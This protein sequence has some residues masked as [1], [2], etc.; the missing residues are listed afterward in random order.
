MC[1]HGSHHDHVPYSRP[2]TAHH[3][4][5]LTTPRTYDTHQL[6]VR[7]RQRDGGRRDDHDATHVAATEHHHLYHYTF[8][9]YYHF[10]KSLFLHTVPR[11]QDAAATE[12]GDDDG[13]SG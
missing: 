10:A 3:G 5:A 11:R 6:D 7:G 4:H 2:R 13:D 12:C 8:H 1:L 9:Y